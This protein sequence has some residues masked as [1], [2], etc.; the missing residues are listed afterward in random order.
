[1]GWV[2]IV[3]GVLTL[4]IAFFFGHTAGGYIDGFFT[5]I[6]YISLILAYHTADRRAYLIFIVVNVS[7][8]DVNS[9][10]R[11]FFH[12]FRFSNDKNFSLVRNFKIRICTKLIER[13]KTNNS[14]FKNDPFFNKQYNFRHKNLFG[15][16]RFLCESWKW[17]DCLKMP[18]LLKIVHLYLYFKHLGMLNRRKSNLPNDF[19]R[20]D[21]SNARRL[22]EVYVWRMG[23]WI[24]Q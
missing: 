12:C 6:T 4:L 16:D 5:I 24:P 9:Y 3:F 17:W 15:F 10:Y 18:V 13:W 11:K 8:F 19:A 22:A 23:W 1:M 21:R 7:T 2:G 20:G 14:V